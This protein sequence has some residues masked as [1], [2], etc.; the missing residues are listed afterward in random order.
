MPLTGTLTK[1]CILLEHS[2]SLTVL[3]KD[4]YE[5]YNCGYNGRW[6]AEEANLQGFGVCCCLCCMLLL[7][8]HLR[9]WVCFAATGSLWLNHKLRA[10]QE[11]CQISTG[12]GLIH[13]VSDAINQ[14]KHPSLCCWVDSCSV[15]LTAR[16]A[17]Q[18]LRWTYPANRLA[19][20]LGTTDEP[21]IQ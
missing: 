3:I 12:E 2:R 5:V 16:S 1:R 15:H 7:C 14:I 10:K 11:C 6:L 19:V 9:V 21:H 13:S 8:V 17:K 4:S 20:Q 18:S